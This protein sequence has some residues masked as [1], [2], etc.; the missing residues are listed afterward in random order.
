MLAI[1]ELPNDYFTTV[2]KKIAVDSQGAIYQLQ[3]TP[4]GVKLT[5]WE[6]RSK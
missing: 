6:Q 3:T 2:N 5:K 1:I 4:T